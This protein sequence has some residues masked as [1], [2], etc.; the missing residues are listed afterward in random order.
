MG[1]E[2]KFVLHVPLALHV[3]LLGGCGMAPG[4]LGLI[5][6]WV[7]FLSLL[8]CPLLPPAT[9]RLRL[10][11]SLTWTLR[12]IPLALTLWC[13][14]ASGFMGGLEPCSRLLLLPLLLAVGGLRP[15]Q[16]QD[17]SDCNCST[18]SPGVLAGIVLGDLVLTVLI[19]LAVY[20]LGR[21]VPRGRGAAEAATRKQRITETESPYQ[22]LQGQR[23]DVYSDLNTQRPYYK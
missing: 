21:L 18:V 22:E 8:P 17:Q 1:M 3:Q 4:C 7:L 14:A 2:M 9:T 15:V 13:P 10:P 12:H 23:S 16:A 20:F 11:P 19:A 6:S 5:L